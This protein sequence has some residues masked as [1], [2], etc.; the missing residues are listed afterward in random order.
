MLAYFH[1]LSPQTPISIPLHL[2][3]HHALKYVLEICTDKHGALTKTHHDLTTAKGV[4][5]KEL[6]SLKAQLKQQAQTIADL[7]RELEQSKANDLAI[8]ARIADLESQLIDAEKTIAI[9]R[10]QVT[11]DEIDIAALKKR[12][13]ELEGQLAAVTKEYQGYKSTSEKTVKELN[14][15]LKLAKD[16]YAQ[17]LKECKL[18]SEKAAK[19]IADLTSAKAAVDKQVEALT[20]QGKKDASEIASQ[21]KQLD[22]SAAKLTALAAEY[23]SYKENSET[24]VNELNASLSKVKDEYAQHLKECKLASEKA[25]KSIADLEAAN[26]QAKEEVAAWTKKHQ[27]LTSSS[28][29]AKSAADKRIGELDGQ[30]KSIIEENELAENEIS[31]LKKRVAELGGKAQGLEQ[32]IASQRVQTKADNDEIASLK[33]QLAELQAS[34]AKGTADYTALTKKHEGLVASSNA[35]IAGKERHTSPRTH[36]LFALLHPCIYSNTL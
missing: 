17:H 31:A 2:P 9:L 27:E 15:G 19:S 32:T 4:V 24:T 6:E 12:I 18:A 1:K 25:A 14:A 23:K 36:T 16:E 8:E 34:Y 33:K 5:D 3:S 7:Q 20:A 26:K 29:A 22:E 10:A 11:K 35:T 21:K 28:A 13:S 30:V